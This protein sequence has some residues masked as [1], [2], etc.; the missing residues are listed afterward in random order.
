LDAKPPKERCFYSTVKGMKD[1]KKPANPEGQGL[2][3]SVKTEDF[4]SM[5]TNPK[6][7]VDF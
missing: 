7:I 2:V 4:S 3:D 1:A 6:K 5:S